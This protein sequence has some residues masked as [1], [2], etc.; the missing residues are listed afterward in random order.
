MD[1]KRVSSSDVARA[2]GVSRA[3]VSAVINNSR[4]VSDV[5]AQHVRQVMRQLDYEPNALARGLKSKRTN[6]LGLVVASLSS[7]YWARVISTMQETAYAHG[8]HIV[9]SHTDEDPERDCLMMIGQQLMV[10]C[11]PLAVVGRDTSLGC[12]TMSPSCYSI[13]PSKHTD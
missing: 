5:L 10:F 12:S 7:P 2:A 1:K 8:F 3:T 13:T 6:S 11:L 4:P 9:L